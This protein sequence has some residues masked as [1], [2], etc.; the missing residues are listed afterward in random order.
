MYDLLMTLVCARSHDIT[1]T[2]G[3]TC[4]NPYSFIENQYSVYVLQRNICH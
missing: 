2:N 3:Q 1:N 4:L